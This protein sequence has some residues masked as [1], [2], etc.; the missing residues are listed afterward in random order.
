[1]SEPSFTKPLTF[2]CSM[3]KFVG[4]FSYIDRLETKQGFDESIIQLRRDDYR[5]FLGELGTAFKSVVSESEIATA[6]SELEDGMEKRWRGAVQGFF[7]LLLNQGLVMSCTIFDS[8]LVDCL[9]ILAPAAALFL[10]TEGDLDK[11]L[12]LEESGLE[13]DDVSKRT[14]EKI[15]KR[16][17][18][19]GIKEKISMMKKA[20]VDFDAALKFKLRV[21]QKSVRG[22]ANAYDFLRFTY[23]RRNH[24][25]HQGQLPVKSYN[26]LHSVYTFFADLMLNVAIVIREKYKIPTD[27]DQLAKHPEIADSLWGNLTGQL[28]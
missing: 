1:M 28:G 18:F 9:T 6:Q 26:D 21:F 5:R 16:F 20:H 23:D 12:E 25:V 8:F 15:L 27:L 10:A 7:P 11:E 3:W 2:T 24:V 19:S 14:E 22:G 17:D 4:V 13:G